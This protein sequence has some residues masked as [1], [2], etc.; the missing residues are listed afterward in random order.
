MTD[1]S[2]YR[3]THPTAWVGYIVFAASMMLLAGC[4]HAI[5]GL[6]AI[7]KDSYYAVPKSGLIVSVDYTA[8]GWFHLI[9]GIV[10]AGAGAAIIAGKTWARIVGVIVAMFSALVNITFL[11]A[12]PVWATIMIAIDVLAIWAL[13]VHGE[14]MSPIR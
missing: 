2:S 6:V 4:F 13:T 11:S 3:R 7:F 12:S 5:A 8:W 14:E 9:L 10:V 1:R